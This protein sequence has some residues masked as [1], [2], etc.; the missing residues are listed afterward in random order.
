MNTMNITCG[1]CAGTGVC[2]MWM[3][4]DQWNG[5][6]TAH[7]EETE[8]PQCGGKGYTEYVMFTPEEAQ[9][10]MKHCGIQTEIGDL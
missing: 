8:C 2:K 7:L 3:V 4:D 5:R 10:I 1:S 9:Q 6:G